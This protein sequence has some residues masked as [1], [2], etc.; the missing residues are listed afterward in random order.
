MCCI[1]SNLFRFRRRFQARP[2]DFR[3]RQSGNKRT[4]NRVVVQLE[5]FVLPKRSFVARGICFCPGQSRFVTG[6]GR[7]FGMTKRN[8]VQ[9]APP[10]RTGCAGLFPSLHLESSVPLSPASLPIKGDV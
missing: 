7:R 6:K 8:V 10:P 4:T 3:S 1:R 2:R 9:T 5:K